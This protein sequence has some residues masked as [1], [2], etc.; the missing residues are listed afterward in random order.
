MNIFV[1]DLDL[2]K[3]AQAHCDQHVIKMILES[4]QIL[5]TVCAQYSIKTPYKPTH[6]NHPCVK[7][8]AASE[9]NWLWLKQLAAELNREYQYRYQCTKNHR[10]FDIILSLKKPPLPNIGLTEFAQAMPEK[11]QISNNPVQAYRSYYVG[12]KSSF[13]KWTRRKPPQWYCKLME[14]KND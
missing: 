6:Q 5:S 7:W 10:S 2:K 8:A 3:C 4:A 9:Q 14:N 1:L 12:E 11:Y 13:A